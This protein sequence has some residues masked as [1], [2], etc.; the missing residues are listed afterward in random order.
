MLMIKVK[1]V[2]MKLFVLD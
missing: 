1:L 2:L